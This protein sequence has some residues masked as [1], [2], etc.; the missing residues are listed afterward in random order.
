[1]EA[2]NKQLI[3]TIKGQ[4][5]IGRTKEELIKALTPKGYTVTEIETAYEL[6]STDSIKSINKGAKWY[7][8][9]GIAFFVV[10]LASWGESVN[11]V[12]YYWYGGTITGIFFIVIGIV[13]FKKS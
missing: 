4:L 5:E 3:T 8:A 9:I 1:M 7:L 6:C 13:K 12:M 10:S 2:V 11:N